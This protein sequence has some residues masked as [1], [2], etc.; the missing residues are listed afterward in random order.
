MQYPQWK[1]FD[2]E[3]D[4]VGG[5]WKANNY[6]NGVWNGG[7]SSMFTLDSS[8]YG[9]WVSLQLPEA[10]SLKSCSFVARSG[11]LHRAPAKFRIYGSSNGTSWTVL[12]AQASELAYSGARASVAVQGLSTY[13]HIAVVVSALPAN[14]DTMNFIKMRI[15]GSVSSPFPTHVILHSRLGVLVL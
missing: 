9:D 6:N 4:A 11:F 2:S 13:T 15:Y 14:G 1:I 3:T 12:H 10:V 8:Y 5:W 7:T